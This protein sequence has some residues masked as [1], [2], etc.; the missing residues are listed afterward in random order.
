MTKGA[1]IGNVRRGLSML[2]PQ[3]DTDSDRIK[4][5]NLASSD[6][7]LTPSTVDGFDPND[8]KHLPQGQRDELQRRVDSFRNIAAA[9]GST[10]PAAKK[11][12]D[13][14]KHELMKIADICGVKTTKG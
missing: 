3:A 10:T 11:E 8:F 5:A 13:D 4:P 6:I 1:F 7:W 2:N 9:V 14:A 12:S